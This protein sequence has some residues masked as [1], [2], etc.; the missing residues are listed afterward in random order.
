[1]SGP[2]ERRLASLVGGFRGRRCLVVGDALL[3]VFEGGRA[4]RL[5]PDAPVPVVT[6]VQ[7]TSCPGGAANVAANLAA[8]GARV[9]FLAAVGEDGA[10]AELLQELAVMGVEVGGVVRERG[11]ATVVKRRI[12]ADGEIL[13]R[14]DSGDA[15][16]LEDA[17]GELLAARAEAQARKEAPQVVVV[18]DYRGGVVTQGLADSLYEARHGCVVLDSK[19]P[20]RL[21]WRGLAAATPNHLEAQKAL[22]LPVEAD[23]DRVDAEGLGEALRRG[24]GSRVLAL[25]LAEK[26]VA[27]VDD[28]GAHHVAGHPV[29]SPD[30]NGAGDSFLAAFAL[31]LGGG[32]PPADAA[33]LGVEAATVAVSRPGTVPVDHGDLLR[34][35]SAGSGGARSGDLVGEPANTSNG[36]A[37]AA[38]MEVGR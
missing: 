18:S 9:T 14:L 23:P 10:G 1:M 36:Y 11:R 3:D 20:L 17:T 27:V 38:G 26:G 34:R 8:L 2:A 22:G 5:A 19:D 35:L 13:A 37:K 4:T 12:V 25:T 28:A 31:A 29:A 16:V 24:I 6:D 32:A 7:V 30:V 33:R 15:G 21:D